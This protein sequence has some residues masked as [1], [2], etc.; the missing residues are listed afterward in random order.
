MNKSVREALVAMRAFAEAAGRQYAKNLELFVNPKTPLNKLTPFAAAGLTAAQCFTDETG[1]AFVV[2][3]HVDGANVDFRETEALIWLANDCISFDKLVQG[4]ESVRDLAQLHGERA[5]ARA[6]YLKALLGGYLRALDAGL[7]QQNPSAGVD[8]ARIATPLTQQSV[9]EFIAGIEA[10]LP[11][12]RFKQEISG[13]AQAM[14]FPT[15][16]LAVGHRKA[17]WEVLNGVA[18]TTDMAQQWRAGLARQRAE[19]K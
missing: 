14:A 18:L 10:I 11:K 5:I 17:Q 4:N 12:V 13:F 3:A 7:L 2:L 8:L 19:H 16:P 15:L 1:E 6:I 9:E